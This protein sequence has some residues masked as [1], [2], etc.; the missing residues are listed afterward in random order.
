MAFDDPPPDD[1]ELTT[2]ER[3]AIAEARAQVDR[4]EGS[5][6]SPEAVEAWLAE[7]APKHR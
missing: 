7:A 4:G 2:E 1:R 3:E 6:M 5:V